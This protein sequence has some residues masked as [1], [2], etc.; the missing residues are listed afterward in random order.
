MDVA[1]NGEIFWFGDRAA[2]AARW[3]AGRKLAIVGGEMYL[4]HRVVWATY[5]GAWTLEPP[6]E[7]HESWESWV[8][9]GLERALAAVAEGWP[10]VDSGSLRYFFA[11]SKSRV[12]NVPDAIS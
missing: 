8:E 5:L 3:L 10:G 11:L 4:R 1:G 12:Q 6:R 9:R 2:E 7:P